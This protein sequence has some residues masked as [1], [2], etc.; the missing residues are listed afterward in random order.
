MDSG[1]ETFLKKHHKPVENAEVKQKR[2]RKQK[3][4]VKAENLANDIVKKRE[5]LEARSSLFNTGPMTVSGTGTNH[6][7]AIPEN[8]TLKTINPGLVQQRALEIKRRGPSQSE[9]HH[10]KTHELLDKIGTTMKDHADRSTIRH[11]LSAA[12]S[13]LQHQ[14]LLEALKGA[15]YVPGS[16]AVAGSSGARGRSRSASTASRVSSVSE[17]S[18]G[19]GILTPLNRRQR[20]RAKAEK[21]RHPIQYSNY[22][23]DVQ[24]LHG[25]Y[26][27]LPL[28]TRKFQGY[29]RDEM[30][31]R[32]KMIHNIRRRE[33][34]RA[35]G[36]D[37][38][39]TARRRA[40]EALQRYKKESGA[41]PGTPASNYLRSEVRVPPTPG[42]PAPKRKGK[43]FTPIR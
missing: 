1:L 43:E 10:M 7:Q 41:P 3:N 37:P 9:H 2:V 25:R 20:E 11:G 34:K 5:A 4:F 13:N 29:T 30:M 32:E 28:D 17:V 16:E 24:E 31:S 23:E 40:T 38:H 18:H 36:G 14:E 42:A 12:N 21:E 15:P 19:E 22:P 33:D 26:L 27:E 39:G 6:M 35:A 8:S